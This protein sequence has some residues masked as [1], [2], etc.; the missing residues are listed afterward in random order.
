MADHRESLDELMRAEGS[1]ALHE[2]FILAEGGVLPDPAQRVE[3]ARAASIRGWLRHLAAAL[4]VERGD[5]TLGSRL[6]RRFVPERLEQL[7][8]EEAAV[9][10]RRGRA[11]PATDARREQLVAWMRVFGE[12]VGEELGLPGGGP[13]TGRAIAAWWRDNAHVATEI[14]AR[15]EV[16]WTTP[17]G[18]AQDGNPYGRVPDVERARE[19]ALVWGHVRALADALEAVTGD[20][21]DV[22]AR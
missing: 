17:S 22:P 14:A 6:E 18:D 12:G 21:P 4:A 7:V 9:T 16:A 11:D 2:E 15:A 20:P 19:A 8:L 1:R 13:A 5:P 10:E 3:R